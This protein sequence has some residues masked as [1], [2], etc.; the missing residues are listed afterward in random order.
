MLKEYQDVF[1]KKFPP[2]LPPKRTIDFKTDLT[3]DVKPQ[4]KGLH[5]LSS[6]EIEDFGEQLHDLLAKIF[7]RPRVSPSGAPV[8][9]VSKKRRWFSTFCGSQSFK[10]MYSEKKLSITEN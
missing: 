2:G 7:I 10:Q 8:L 4:K 1:L 3:T 6:K 9:F 5:R